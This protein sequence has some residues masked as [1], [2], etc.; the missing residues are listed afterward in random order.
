MGRGRQGGEEERAK[1]GEEEASGGS[2][3]SRTTVPIYST[4]PIH[5]I[6]TVRTA[7]YMLLYQDMLL[8]NMISIP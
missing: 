2:C 6:Q 5:T 7:Y 1:A 4:I 3:A 8:P